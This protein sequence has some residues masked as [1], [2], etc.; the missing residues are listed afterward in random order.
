LNAVDATLKPFGNKI[1]VDLQPA[2]KTVGTTTFEQA[3]VWM[4]KEKMEQEH[5]PMSHLYV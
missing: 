3:C 1:K 5:N 2:R 4:K